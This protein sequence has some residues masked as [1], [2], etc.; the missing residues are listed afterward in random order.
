[1][2]ENNNNEPPSN[3]GTATREYHGMGIHDIFAEEIAPA[4]E[5]LNVEV[6]NS[7][8][9][10]GA[11]AAGGDPFSVDELDTE[12]LKDDEKKTE[13]KKD[14]KKSGDRKG[15]DDHTGQPDAPGEKTGAAVKLLN[16]E[17]PILFFDMMAKRVGRMAKPECPD[18]FRFAKEDAD[19]FKTLLKFTIEEE[20]LERIPSK[21]LLLTGL[22]FWGFAKW[23]AWDKPHLWNQDTKAINGDEQKSEAPKDAEAYAE[24]IRAK[25]KEDAENGNKD[26]RVQFQSAMEMNARLHLQMKNLMD[27][28]SGSVPGANV[29]NMN[30]H[31][32]AEE[33]PF[34]E[35]PPERYMPGGEHMYDMEAID[36]SEGGCIVDKTKAGLKG[37]AKDGRKD[38]KP[39]KR[40]DE[41]K[42]HFQKYHAWKKTHIKIAS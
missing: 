32:A 39:S 20:N 10:N 19:D 5:I 9:G 34:T 26:L 42:T 3:G 15:K 11:A 21:W 35:I 37:F 14:D 4:E 33:I 24:Y 22:G 31:G 41:I 30:G 40:D 28:I 12:E 23:Y 38:G 8:F 18:Y 16:P 6:N 27:I 25:A 13:P 36:F 17:V 2:E 1:M 7:D 29:H